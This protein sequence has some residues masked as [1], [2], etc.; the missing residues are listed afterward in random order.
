MNTGQ[1]TLA[2]AAAKTSASGGNFPD[3]IQQYDAASTSFDASAK[4]PAQRRVEADK[5]IASANQSIS[6]T[7]DRLDAIKSEMDAGLPGGAE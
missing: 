5:A 2:Y 7:K 6:D 1:G 3:A 4:I